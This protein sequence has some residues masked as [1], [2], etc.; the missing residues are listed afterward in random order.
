MSLYF[1]ERERP[2]VLLWLLEL[3]G[4]DVRAMEK[5]IRRL[6]REVEVAE[7]R[8]VDRGLAKELNDLGLQQEVE[9]YQKLEQ[10]LRAR[11]SQYTDRERELDA[12]L[13]AAENTTK[14][15]ERRARKLGW[16]SPLE[17]GMDPHVLRSYSLK[18]AKKR[19]AKKRTVKR[20]R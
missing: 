6:E 9:G 15:W 12:A 16:S 7:N 17:Y 1:E 18:S 3:L 14:L 4:Y 13:A 11:L 20:G 5:K 19:S 2:S 8:K 10:E